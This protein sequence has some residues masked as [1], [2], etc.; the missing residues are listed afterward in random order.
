M[1]SETEQTDFRRAAF[2]LWR[3]LDNID[4]LDDAWREDDAGF[5]KSAYAMQRRRFQFLGT[6]DVDELYADYLA[7]LPDRNTTEAE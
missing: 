6:V 4:T 2:E 7:P 1:A 5:R 3:L